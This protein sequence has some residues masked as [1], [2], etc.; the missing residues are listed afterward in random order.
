MKKRLLKKAYKR[1]K[2]ENQSLEKLVKRPLAIV[3]IIMHSQGSGFLRDFM[4][5][6]NRDGEELDLRRTIQQ[7][8]YNALYR[9]RDRELEYHKRMESALEE[10]LLKCLE[11]A[12]PSFAIPIA[13]ALDRGLIPS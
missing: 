10:Q 7:E 4:V 9:W 1:V 6:L 13:A 2:A 3:R 8:F 5:E 12:T 11:V